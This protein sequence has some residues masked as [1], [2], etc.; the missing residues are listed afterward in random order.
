MRAPK[1]LLALLFATLAAPF[2]S[3]AQAAYAPAYEFTATSVQYGVLGSFTMLSDLFTGSTNDFIPNTQVLSLS[4][5]NPRTSEVFTAP[6]NPSFGT[7][8]N[9]SGALPA[10]VTGSDALS[11]TFVSV[12]PSH[13][14]DVRRISAR[15]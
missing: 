7:F 4:F 13:P 6:G 9:T 2:A 8:L 15:G 12:R 11:G 3:V 14:L 10:I 1:L 5:A